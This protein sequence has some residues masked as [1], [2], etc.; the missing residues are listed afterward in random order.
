MAPSL[1]FRN[2]DY[3]ARDC[4]KESVSEIAASMASR[5]AKTREAG[6]T[7][8]SDPLEAGPVAQGEQICASEGGRLDESGA[9]KQVVVQIP[10]GKLGSIKS[11]AEEYR[12]RVDACLSWAKEAPTDEVRLACLML[13]QAWLRAAIRNDRTVSEHL[14][15]APT[16]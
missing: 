1:A 10:H 14:P 15:L 9:P 16:L 7:V 5:L 2:G 12:G 13:A 8:S 6:G 3:A 4:A 11:S